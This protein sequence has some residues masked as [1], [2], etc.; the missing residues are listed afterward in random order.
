MLLIDGGLINN[1]PVDV[2]RKM[3]A[4]IV[5][6]VSFP[7][8][9]KAIEK[10]Q[11]SISEVTEQIWHFIG[12]EKR[13]QNLE[14]ADILIMPVLHP[15]GS[16][17]FQQQAIDSIIVR[18]EEAAMREWEGLMSL[19]LS[20]GLDSIDSPGLARKVVNPY[21]N[22]DTLLIKDVRVEG[23]SPR[24]E[25]QVLRWISLQDEKV[26][27]RQLDAM[28]ARVFGTGL[29]SSVHYRLDGEGLSI[30]CLTWSQK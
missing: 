9:E 18:G 12:T 22:V 6:A 4:D 17:D 16:M 11:G 7:P 28:T 5:I 10:G 19:K 3:G 25:R 8:D 15:Y 13:T 29:F 14:D 23:V 21:I 27:R 24:E 2:A 30:S 1:T 20:L 26:T